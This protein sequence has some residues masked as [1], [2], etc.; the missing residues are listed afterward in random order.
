MYEVSYEVDE[1]SE[2]AVSNAGTLNAKA[3]SID[4]KLKKDQTTTVEGGKTLTFTAVPKSADFM[5]AGW[6]VNGKKVENELSN[7]CVIEELDKKVH[8]TV[9]FTQYKGYALPTAN[10]GYLLS[11]MK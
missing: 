2:G 5:V 7:T 8:V 1:T 9:Q 11:E 10:E 3:G 6:Y 4:L